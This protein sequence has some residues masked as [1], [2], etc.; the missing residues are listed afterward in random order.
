[1]T[2]DIDN[3]IDKLVPRGGDKP[4]TIHTSLEEYLARLS[5]LN[6]KISG[7]KY[8]ML[9][10]QTI[11]HEH[12]AEF[13]KRINSIDFPKIYE[14]WTSK[15]FTLSYSSTDIRVENEFEMLLYSF[16]STLNTLTRV[17]A[18]FLKGSTQIHS[19]SK[20][21][22][23]L[24][25]H[26]DFNNCHQTALTAASSWAEELTIRRDAATH[27]IAILTDSTMK[28]SKEDL[29]GF[30]TTI[31][32]VGIP[33]VPTKHISIWNDQL[34]VKGGHKTFTMHGSDGTQILELKDHQEN[35]IVKRVEPLQKVELIDGEQ[36]IRNVYD[37]FQK[38][39]SE[40]LNLLL[41]RLNCKSQ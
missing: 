16:I 11:C 19:H 39:L 41:V 3:L 4:D 7:T 18:C 5:S 22:D 13:E 14:S 12:I 40:I 34:P 24:L 6:R 32:H 9:S 38:H 31:L 36:Y 21:P 25:K 20:L 8:R 26:V 29:K 35:L 28:Q 10:W 37:Y 15:N 33:K 30:H 17:I 23:I 1:M 2:S 27:Y